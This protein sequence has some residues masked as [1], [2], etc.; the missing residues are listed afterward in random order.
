MKILRF[1]TEP[2]TFDQH[3]IL[4]TL[5]P[6]SIIVQENRRPSIETKDYVKDFDRLALDYAVVE[7]ETGDE[8]D[9]DMLKYVSDVLKHSDFCRRGG[10]II[11]LVP[12]QQDGK[13]YLQYEQVLAAKI[14]SAQLVPRD[15]PAVIPPPPAEESAVAE[16]GQSPEED[17]VDVK[18]QLENMDP[19]KPI[20]EPVKK[21]SVKKGK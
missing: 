11:R 3:Q 13:Q 20:K 18:E 14:I 9:G 12:S 19:T 8:D 1:T 17:V 16:E 6:N 21:G 5:W 15:Q 2:I 10:L 7:L 4:A